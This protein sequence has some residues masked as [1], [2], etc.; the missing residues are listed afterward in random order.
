MRK[1][2]LIA[3]TGVG[4]ALSGAALAGDAEA[5][6]AKFNEVCADCHYEDDFAGESQEAILEKIN[7]VRSGATEHQEDL[8]GLTDE[9]AAGIAAFW[10]SQG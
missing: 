6:K 9:E 4:F 2:L 3:V 10:A 5:G 8:S 1:L 7:G